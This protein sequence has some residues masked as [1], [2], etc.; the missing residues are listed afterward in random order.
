MIQ[1]HNASDSSGNII[2]VKDVTPDI[3]KTTQYFCLG[4]GAEMEAVL[5]KQKQHHFRHKEKCNCSPETYY[6]R[7]GKIVLKQ[8]FDNQPQF[9]VNYYV[10]NHCDNF[11]NCQLREKH[12]WQDC[13]AKVL[14]TINLKEYY[15]TCEEEVSYGGFRAD[16]MLTHSQYPDRRPVFLEISVTHDCEPEKTNSK[17]RI[18]EIKIQSEIDALRYFNRDIEEND[19]EFVSAKINVQNT[20]PVRFYNFKR[21]SEASYPL[22]R[23]YL[24]KS[25]DGIFHGLLKLNAVTCHNVET[26]HE[27]NVCFE[28]SIS[29]DKIPKKE[30]GNLYSV[31]MALA[32]KRGFRVKNCILCAHYDK[33][34]ITYNNQRFYASQLSVSDLEQ[35]CPAYK[36][37]KYTFYKYS[38]HRIINSFK[39]IP[40]LEWTKL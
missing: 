31:G 36:C 12:H 18:I 30:Y 1:Y 23:F 16:L 10:Q 28:I 14:K 3:R 40:Y 6:H 38:C 9:L 32:I 24:V 22:S 19:G 27:E 21:K 15:D 37:G 20:L 33:C 7:L 39:R 35:L 25:D 13:S 17:I 8:K 29:E 4:C 2:E 26:E 5:G 11:E 34:T